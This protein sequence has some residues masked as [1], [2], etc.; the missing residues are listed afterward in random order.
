MNDEMIKEEVR[1]Q[2]HLEISLLSAV[3]TNRVYYVLR[4]IGKIASAANSTW[5]LLATTPRTHLIRIKP[6]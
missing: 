1:L 5:M 6:I 4:L 3:Q 2:V